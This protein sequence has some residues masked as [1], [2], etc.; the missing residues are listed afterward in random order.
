MESTIRTHMVL[1]RNLV[2]EFD[3]RV[4]KGKRSETVA[5]LIE[6]WMRL[7][8]RREIWTRFAGSIKAED[9]PEWATEADIAAWSRSMKDRW[10]DP[11]NG[12]RSEGTA[13]DAVSP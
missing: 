4:G 11:L 2:E 1:P 5:A 3:H 6:E 9:H 8:R 12:D 13:S 7:E 10:E